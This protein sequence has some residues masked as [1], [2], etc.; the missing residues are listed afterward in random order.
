VSIVEGPRA[1]RCL[2]VAPARP[3]QAAAQAA[4][5]R[6]LASEGVQPAVVQ[7]D[8]G[9]CFIG[10]ETGSV[11]VPG[12][13]TLWLW[14]LG[15]EHR[16]LP[17]RRPQRN[18]AVER[19]H[20]ALE[21][22][23]QGEPDGLAA[24]L[25]VWNQGKQVATPA[26]T[27][28]RGRAGSDLTR[29]WTGLARVQVQRR[30]TRQGTISLWDRPVRVGRSWVEQTVTLTFDAVHQRLGIRDAYDTLIREHDLLWLT[31][32]WLWATVPVTDHVAHPGVTSS[33]R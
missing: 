12:R 14:S 33:E 13:L 23:W 15:I 1:G 24:L 26:T 29:V 27:P 2:T 16:L 6:S 11:A 21:R 9:A 4:L 28:Y 20:G 18:G 8:R 22:S 19:L 31:C 25:P 3:R 10:T 32:D 5:A 30:V 17:P 7:T